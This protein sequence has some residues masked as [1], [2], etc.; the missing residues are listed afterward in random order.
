MAMGILRS[1]TPHFM[2]KSERDVE[3]KSSSEFNERLW[4][5]IPQPPR[6]DLPAFLPEGYQQAGAAAPPLPWTTCES[7]G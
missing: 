3:A 5:R 6:K 1:N 2:L 7:L 4:P